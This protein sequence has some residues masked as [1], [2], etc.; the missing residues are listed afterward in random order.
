M[1]Y[2]FLLCLFVK[3][4]CL[5]LCALSPLVDIILFVACVTN[6]REQ[7]APAGHTHSAPAGHTHFAPARYAHSAPARYAHYALHAHLYLAPSGDLWFKSLALTHSCS[8]N[9]TSKYR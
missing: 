2:L 7:Y 5:L 8:T 4:Y 9:F 3:L 1:K 6:V